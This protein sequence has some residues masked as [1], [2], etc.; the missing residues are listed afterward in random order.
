MYAKIL[1]PID[2]SDISKLALEE[3]VKLA[4]ALHASLRLLH[5]LDVRPLLTCEAAAGGFDG[6]FEVM[7]RDGAQLLQEAAASI[8]R[9][10]IQVDTILVEA[11]DGQVG[12]CIVRKAREYEAGLIVCGTH[13]RRGVPRLL[14]G[15]DAD[16]IVRHSP[17]PVVLVRVPDPV[18]EKTTTASGAAGQR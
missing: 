5:V 3:A 9:D 17:V 18:T 1:V 12:E 7:R 16:Y 10:V 8:P 11:P 14:L 4:H 6:V 15:S 2:G 13:G